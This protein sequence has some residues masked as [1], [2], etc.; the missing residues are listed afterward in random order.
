MKRQE[1][2]TFGQR[3]ILVGEIFITEKNCRLINSVDIYSTPTD[4]AVS[5]VKW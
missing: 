1:T 4:L 5:G 3:M 2:S